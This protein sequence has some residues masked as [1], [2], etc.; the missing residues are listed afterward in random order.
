[1]NRLR[2]NIHQ[3]LLAGLASL[4]GGRGVFSLREDPVRVRGDVELFRVFPDGRRELIDTAPNLVV[5]LG[6]R[7]MSR[8]IGGVLNTP[9][10]LHNTQPAIRLIRDTD[11]VDGGGGAAT[12]AW[13]RFYQIADTNTFRFVTEATDGGAPVVE[14]DQ[15]F[16]GGTKTIAQL[17]ADIDGHARWYASVVGSVGSLD[18]T[19]LLR[20][21]DAAR[22]FAMGSV[23]SYGGGFSTSPYLRELYMLSTIEEGSLTAPLLSV[24][25]IRFGTE[26][27][28][29]AA[30]TL[31]KDVLASDER[32]DGAIRA[33]DLG[34][35]SPA[36][37]Y[38]SVSPTYISTPS[39][40][41]FVATLDQTDANGR[42]ISEVGLYTNGDALVAK[43]TF[44]QIAK[45][46]AF[47]IEIRWTLIFALLLAMNVG[48]FFVGLLTALSDTSFA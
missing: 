31:G 24:S 21:H 22:L 9:T 48:M 17:V 2:R 7:V 20:N 47:A 18:A 12:D 26:G 25:R 11:V 34:E 39:Q 10:L 42:S 16:A 1:M 44:G 28:Q 40:I 46:N 15:T 27:H 3:R 6:R 33:S 30:P 36:D 8:L 19:N 45:T 14:V 38:L 32:L 4:T 23:A 41:T 43:K 37:D 35:A 29:P 5:T 13:V